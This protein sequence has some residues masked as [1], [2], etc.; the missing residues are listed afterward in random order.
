MPYFNI[1]EEVFKL[2]ILGG[3]LTIVSAIVMIL[4]FT[5]EIRDYL[6][7][8]LT[9]ELF[10]DTSRSGKL[11]INFDIVFSRI[12]CDYLVSYSAF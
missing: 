5:S 9:E 10:V 6:T 7:P 3:V 11:K 12:S 2:I 4:L 1:C 8:Q